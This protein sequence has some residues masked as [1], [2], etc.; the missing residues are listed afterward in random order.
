MLQQTWI[1]NQSREFTEE[2]RDDDFCRDQ[3]FFQFSQN[4]LVKL[5]S[6]NWSKNRNEKLNI[7]KNREV[8][9][10]AS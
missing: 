5:I 3:Q 4:L 8:N 7:L 6:Y 10:L 2:K 1:F 9:V